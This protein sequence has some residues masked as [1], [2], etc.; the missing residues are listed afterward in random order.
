MWP[1]LW[2]FPSSRGDVNPIDKRKTPRW[3][4]HPGG[5]GKVSGKRGEGGVLEKEEC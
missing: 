3:N 4:A 1:S 2:S 5:R